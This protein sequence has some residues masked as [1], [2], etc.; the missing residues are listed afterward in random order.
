MNLFVTAVAALIASAPGTTDTLRSNDQTSE[1]LVA[2]QTAPP[3]QTT[4]PAAEAKKEEKK[5]DPYTAAT[6]GFEKQ[7]GVVR[8]FKKDDT[9]LFE[10]PKAILGRDFAWIIELKA[11]PTGGYGGN[12]ANGA[13][14][15]FEKK[16]E[17]VIVRGIDYSV[18][19]TSGPEIQE[20]VKLA[21]VMPILA[22]LDVKAKGQDDSLLVDVSRFF[23]GELPET[24][25]RGFFRGAGMDPSRSFIDKVNVFP[26][27]INVEIEA[28]FAGGGAPSGPAGFGFGGAPARPSNTAVVHHSMVLL[29]EQPMKGRLADDR[30]GY[31]SYGVED[32]G[33]DYH[34]AKNYEYIARY[35]LE[36]KDPDAAV[37]EPVKPIVY[38]ISRE[39]PKKWWPYVKAGVEEWQAAFEAAGFKNAIVCKPAPTV[40]EDPKWSPEDAR[41]S[42]IRWAPLP[43]ANAM[44]PHYADPRSGEILSA[45]I[46]MWHDIMKLQTDWYFAQASATDPAAQR[47]PFPDD[48]MGRCVQFVVAHEVGHTLGLPH[49]MKASSTTPIANLRDKQWVAENGTCPSIM[50][51]ARFNYVAQPGDGAATIPKV[52]VYDKFSIMWGY[53][54]IAAA[55][56]WDEKST[57]DVWAGQQEKNPMLRF[58]NPSGIDPTS[59]SEALG[60][61]AVEASTLGTENLKRTMSFVEAAT[62]KH[63]EDYSELTRQYSNLLGQFSLYIGHVSQVVGGVVRTNYHAGRG[64]AVFK[65]A[66]REYQARSVKWLL[67]NVVVTP[68]WATPR[69]VLNKIGLSAGNASVTGLQSRVFGRLLDNSRLGRMLENEASNGTAAYT[70]SEMLGT[71]RSE[72]WKEL[73]SSSPTIDL[74]RRNMQRLYVNALVGKLS[75]T[76]SEVRAIAVSELKRTLSALDKGS[77]KTS[78]TMTKAHLDDLKHLVELALK[79]PAQAIAQAGGNVIR[80]GIDG[81]EHNHA[82]MPCSFNRARLGD[83]LK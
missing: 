64:D 46:I 75:G 30:V 35:R 65:P 59:M 53:K 82:G 25:V 50:D 69:S 32:Y 62:E 47:I 15:R 10:L 26:N 8:V 39:V 11:T 73:G 21:N 4:T 83:L 76:S 70:V 36:K 81:D 2:L 67:D 33:T 71:V 44:G 43:I 14:I 74:Q 12:D 20:A 40:E 51:Y 5:E 41:Y 72:V 42:V 28:T 61:D 1:D 54:P 34:G 78:D 77:S 79:F 6:K 17:K 66:A 55:T 7:D 29:P 16:N 49:N 22:A 52:G 38:Y 37:S 58:D 63:G 56:P 3:A 13:L 45:H 68:T 18:R 31:F 27:N 24:S 80:L 19:A 57:L 9:V 23:K 60:D 48:L